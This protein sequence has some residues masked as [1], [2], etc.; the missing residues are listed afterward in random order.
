MTKPRAKNLPAC[1]IARSAVIAL[2]KKDPEYGPTNYRLVFPT[3]WTKKQLLDYVRAIH[4]EATVK[5]V[6]WEHAHS[7]K[8]EP[9]LWLTNPRAF[10]NY[11]KGEMK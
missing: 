2:R 9:L 11:K 5:I 6:K 3:E 8:G 7:A 10:K 1:F 4:T